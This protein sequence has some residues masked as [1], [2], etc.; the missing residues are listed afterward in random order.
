MNITK[1]LKETE[2]PPLSTQETT[3]VMGLQQNISVS[4]S[5][6]DMRLA[7]V[8]SSSLARQVIALLLP[9][10][11]LLNIPPEIRNRIFSYLLVSSILGEADSVSWSRDFGRSQVYGLHSN[12]LYVCKQLYQEGVFI[13]YGNHIFMDCSNSPGPWIVDCGNEDELMGNDEDDENQTQEPF[14]I[15]LCPLTRYINNIPRVHSEKP[16]FRNTPGVS[17]VRVWNVLLTA[18]NKEDWT[19]D[20]FAEFCVALYPHSQISV[21]IS[22]VSMSFQ[23]QHMFLAE[24]Q[25]SYADNGL[26]QT[27]LPLKMLR[28]LK[29]LVFKTAEVDA[30]PDYCYAN[31]DPEPD[32]SFPDLP[33]PDLER[34]YLQL[35]KGASPVV[36]PVGRMWNLFSEYAGTFK[37]V[38][39]L[40]S[41]KAYPGHHRSIRVHDESA[42]RDQVVDGVLVHQDS[43]CKLED[44]PSF[45]GAEAIG[46]A[47]IQPLLRDSESFEDLVKF[48]K[49][50]K[51]ILELLEPQY[52]RVRTC[53]IRVREQLLRE[54]GPTGLFV[55]GPSRA[56][57]LKD[58]W[59]RMSKVVELLKEY[60]YSFVKG[61]TKELQN[62]IQSQ[63]K[64][65]ILDYKYLERRDSMKKVIWYHERRNWK[66]FTASYKHTFE[67]LENVFCHMRRCRKDL[68]KWDVLENNGV[69]LN[70]QPELFEYIIWG[71]QRTNE[72]LDRKHIIQLSES[73]NPEDISGSPSSSDEASTDVYTAQTAE[74][75]DSSGED[76]DNIKEDSNYENGEGED[77]DDEDSDY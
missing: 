42:T 23:Y 19:S 65:I 64:F 5:N 38:S 52:Q 11:S 46:E 74:M 63:N 32:P 59:D 28:N 77:S 12:I 57:N 14:I 21:N 20:P 61:L 51:D 43:P 36:E 48:K 6:Q 47:P 9:K 30:I 68:F 56:V 29:N 70:I 24:E 53:S 17:H 60:E 25:L 27:L 16:L 8:P 69:G 15:N 73:E 31:S 45:L 4:S 62:D 75:T 18:L 2:E 66:E 72:R 67:C 34:E 37:R 50:R 49:Y 22:I 58:Y 7:T 71:Q 1:I 35:T 3:S 44:E 39:L 76:T 55:I 10:H 41:N 33:S 13:L 26:I 54:N 40:I